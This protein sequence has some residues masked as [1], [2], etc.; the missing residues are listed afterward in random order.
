MRP[1]QGNVMSDQPLASAQQADNMGSAE[2]TRK[3]K[4]GDR[5]NNAGIQLPSPPQRE[6]DFCRASFSQ[7]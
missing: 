4:G 1:E 2:E 3:V 7:S 6:H 5:L